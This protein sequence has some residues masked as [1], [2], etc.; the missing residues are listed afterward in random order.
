MTDRWPEYRQIFTN[1]VWHNNHA[2][3]A[4]LGLCPLLAV[5]NSVVNALGLG[6]ATLLVLTLSNGM[7]S[8]VRHWITPEIRIPA[9]ITIIAGLVTAV[10]LLMSTL[11]PTLHHTLGIFIPLIVTNCIVLARAEAYASK[12]SIDR[13]LLDGFSIG[14]GFLLALVVLG[15]LREL[16]GNGTLLADAQLLFGDVAAHWTLHVVNLNYGMLIAILPPGAFLGLG[17]M[18]AAT[19]AIKAKQRKQQASSIAIAVTDIGLT[20]QHTTA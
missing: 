16:F 2:L 5:S 19:N 12:H 10:D 9:Y 14:F 6:V 13:A 15:G 3:V 7:V 1:G 17:L 11:T 18:I 20:K 4:L 8:F